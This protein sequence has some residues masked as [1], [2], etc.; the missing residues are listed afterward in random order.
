MLCKIE[1]K[2]TQILKKNFW[3]KQVV[4]FKYKKPTILFDNPEVTL[5]E[6]NSMISSTT[7][8]F[9]SMY[10]K[11]VLQFDNPGIRQNVPDAESNT[12]TAVYSAG[13]IL[14]LISSENSSEGRS[15]EIY[16]KNGSN[17]QTHYQIGAVTEG[18]QRLVTGGSSNQESIDFI[19]KKTEIKTNAATSTFKKGFIKKT[20]WGASVLL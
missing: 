3:K 6:M 7:T 18:T 1:L 20:S 9:S 13:P 4:A 10:Q 12:S 17:T 11:A 8:Y 19:R 2:L 5:P 16:S 15:R 14:H